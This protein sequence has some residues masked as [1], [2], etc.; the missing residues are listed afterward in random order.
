MESREKNKTQ[1]KVKKEKS[2]VESRE[3]RETQQRKERLSDAD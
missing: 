3:E 1:L 2:T